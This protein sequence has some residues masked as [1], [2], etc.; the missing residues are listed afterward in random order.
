MIRASSMFGGKG[1]MIDKLQ[2]R[3]GGYET[4]SDGCATLRHSL[5]ENQAQLRGGLIPGE[6]RAES[7]GGW[8]ALAYLRRAWQVRGGRKE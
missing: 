2:G 3:G 5:A 4:L 8:R 7:K 1:S 6:V